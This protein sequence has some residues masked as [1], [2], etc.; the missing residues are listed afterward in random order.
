[1]AVMHQQ[2]K[3]VGSNGQIS[4][5]KE[6]AGKAVLLDQLDENTWIIKSGSFVP[7]SETWLHHPDHI[8]KLEK[9]LHFAEKNK[10]KDNFEKFTKGLTHE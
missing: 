9:A 1:M 3:V 4:L 7:H 6:F 2:I 5:G 8:H 10:P